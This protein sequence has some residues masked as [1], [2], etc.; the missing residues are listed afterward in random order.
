M[1]LNRGLSL[2]WPSS[3]Q[4]EF[5]NF[6][7]IVWK[8]MRWTP[9]HGRAW[10]RDVLPLAVERAHSGHCFSQTALAF[11]Q[12]F[13]ILKWQVSKKST[14]FLAIFISRGS[15]KKYI[16]VLMI[17]RFKFSVRQEKTFKCQTWFLNF[18]L[19]AHNQKLWIIPNRE[20]SVCV[21]Y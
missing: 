7:G 14:F 12:S 9:A 4:V 3:Y 15:L 5:K 16:S 1:I 10:L 13:I 21:V 17:L 2:V 20:Q 8:G 18:R 19:P 11:V 6:H